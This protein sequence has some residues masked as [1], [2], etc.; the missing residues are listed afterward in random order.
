MLQMCMKKH[1]TLAQCKMLTM[2]KLMLQYNFCIL[3]DFLPLFWSQ[4]VI[5]AGYQRSTIF[6]L[7][8]APWLKSAHGYF[9]VYSRS[10]TKITK[11]FKEI[12]FT[13]AAMCMDTKFIYTNALYY[14]YTTWGCCW[15]EFHCC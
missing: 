1:G 10:I 5:S 4:K 7:L 6:A 11:R 12:S 2:N 3:L 9:Y 8:K 15:A 13:N 14:M